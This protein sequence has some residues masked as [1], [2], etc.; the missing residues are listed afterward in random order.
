MLFQAREERR[1]DQ[2]RQIAFW[3]RR[4]RRSSGCGRDALVATRLLEISQSDP[5]LR[6]VRP[7]K[8]AETIVTTRAAANNRSNCRHR[9][10]RLAP[11][12][13]C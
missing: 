2:R 5:M 11:S 10:C 7:S 3:S 9:N 12:T 6:R 8:A 4:R 1:F 13:A